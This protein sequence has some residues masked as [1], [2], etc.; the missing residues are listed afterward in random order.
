M[1]IKGLKRGILGHKSAP[2]TE[3]WYKKPCFYKESHVNIIWDISYKQLGQFVII[4]VYIHDTGGQMGTK[5]KSFGPKSAL[6]CE[7][8]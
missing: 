2:N 4:H 5:N 8:W 1:T 6:N 7:Y 3:N